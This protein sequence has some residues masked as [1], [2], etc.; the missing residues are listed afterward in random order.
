MK[1]TDCSRP[2]S[3]E[4]SLPKIACQPGS[5]KEEKWEV[6][7]CIDFTD[8]NKACLNGSFSLL[9]V[10]QMDDATAGQELLIFMDAY[11]GYNQIKIHPSDEVKTT[12]TVDRV[13]YCYKVMPFGLKNAGATFQ[14]MVNEVFKELI[15]N[16]MEVYVN[17]MLVKSLKC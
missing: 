9:S 16:I 13:V 5:S 10:D 12:F 14:Q 17:E 8:L 1:L 6:E 11:P 4:N 3:S 2:V 15:R 7:V